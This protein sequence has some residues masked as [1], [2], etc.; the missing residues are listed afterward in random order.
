MLLKKLFSYMDYLLCSKCGT[1]FSISVPQTFCP[2]CQETLVAHYQ[3]KE[4]NKTISKNDFKLR[5][6]GLWRWH[7]L[8]PIRSENQIITL[9][10]G[11]TPLLNL[12]RLADN[13][14][15]QS[16]LLKDE[17][18]NPTHCFK[19]R[20]LAA[21]V[22]SARAF[23]ITDF[24]IPTAGNAGASLATYAAHAHVHAHIIM[25]KDTPSV[26]IY[27]SRI[28]GA[29]VM[30]VEGR[31]DDAGVIARDLAARH[32]WFDVSTFREPFRLEGK[33]IMGY[34]IA[35][36]MHWK[37]PGVIFYPTG[38]GT[39]LVGIWKAFQEMKEMGWLE[40][41]RLPRMI[42]VQSAGCAPV[43]KAYEAHADHCEKWQD[44]QT[45]AFGLR[46][47][48][49][50]A[51]RLIMQTIYESNGLAVAV[52]DEEILLAQSL[53]AREE[54]IFVCPEGAANLAALKELLHNGQIQQDESILLLNTGSGLLNMDIFSD[55]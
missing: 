3:L 48:K 30:L 40:T 8:L 39:G 15:F 12:L 20:G 6:R 47:P 38:G 4:V 49:S 16:L 11:D 27:Q 51:D 14:G 21:A 45:I 55:N 29:D 10:E 31:I 1:Q 36:A 24:V 5:P 46:V 2:D 43:V 25:P 32:H 19:A 23:G 33:K 34:E 26:N 44:S 18:T 17:G 7:E 54:G 37:L 22:S 9:G 28:A 50:F 52:P 35:E 41:D 42:A 13:L 53:L